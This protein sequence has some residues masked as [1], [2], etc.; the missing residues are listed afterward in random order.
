M[1]R[2]R[3]LAKGWERVVGSARNV[4]SLLWDLEGGV[5]PDHCALEANFL[6]RVSAE[7][8]WVDL[9]GIGGLLSSGG[10]NTELLLYAEREAILV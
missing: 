2:A 8:Q 5:N 6:V 10:G 9:C 7:G 3:R 4:T 1:Y